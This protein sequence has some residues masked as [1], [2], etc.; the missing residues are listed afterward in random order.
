MDVFFGLLGALRAIPDWVSLLVLPALLVPLAAV[1]LLVRRPKL[2]AP[3]ASAL[4]LTGTA[5]F[6]ARGGEGTVVYIALFALIALLLRPLLLWKRKKRESR[7]ERIY[8]T[9]H[10]D[11]DAPPVPPARKGE[12]ALPPKVCCFETPPATES[13]IS[14]GHV[15]ALIQKLKKEKLAA[16]DRL[17]LEALSR[18]VDGCKNRALTEPERDTLNDCLASVLRM[19]AKYK[20]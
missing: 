2:Y 19:T 17:E 10:E 9:F 5:L 4:G 18:T 1:L 15:T 20:L 16:A 8:R 6:A 11:L 12:A 3:L 13:D 14:L 7:D